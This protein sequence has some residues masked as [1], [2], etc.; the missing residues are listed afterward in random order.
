M[1]KF[2]IKIL[3]MMLIIL[4]SIAIVLVSVNFF[5]FEKFETD[6]KASATKCVINLNNSIDL[7]E[8]QK[9][10][11]EKSKDSEEYK[12]VLNS[13][14]SAKSESIARNFY[15]L[16]RTEGKE[17][18]FLLDVSVDS[19]EFLEDYTMDSEMEKAFY[20]NVT[21]S[22]ESLTDEYGTYITACAPIKNSAG[23]VIA[24]SGVDIDTSMFEKIRSDLI[25]IIISTIIILSIIAVI[26]IFVFSNKVSKNIKKIQFA[27]EKMRYGDFSYNL[28]LKTKDELEVIAFS[29]NKVKDSLKN[30][31]GNVV[32]VANDM[33]NVIEKVNTKMGDLNLD[34]E[35]VSINTEDLSANIEETAAS[36][37]EMAG[38]SKEIGDVVNSIAGKSQGISDKATAISEKAKNIMG[39]SETN[40]K[41]TEKMFIE[42]DTRLKNSIE[43][44][45]AVEQINV[46]SDS[47]LEITSQTNLLALNA[48]IEAARA[49]EAGKGFSVV[50][51]EIRKLA[52]ESSEA[53]SKIQNV[54][55]IIVMSVGELAENSQNMLDFI[56]NKVL[57]DYDTLIDISHQYNKDA[58]YYKDFS[59]ELNNVS[60]DLLFSVDNMIKTIEGV[61][62]AATEGATETAAIANKVADVNS[63]SSDIVEETSKAKISSEKLKEDISKFIV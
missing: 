37:E 13:M 6:I 14:T 62:G 32:I 9:I 52:E 8:I 3:K 17:A 60:E 20:G 56:E 26:M 47:I 58:L 2:G 16:I 22:E 11:N 7:N 46:L 24:I 41:E 36:A 51:D 10:I 40:Q 57:K 53:I 42:T 54:T 23:K 61:A 31:I 44:A 39:I 34:I 4:S 21:V 50:A 43:K 63:K 28:E 45:K 18:K 15:I 25:K 55:G 48:A 33:D 5:M 1:S 19:S 30:L 38:C 35:E 59:L 27:L 49:G 29:I 12:N